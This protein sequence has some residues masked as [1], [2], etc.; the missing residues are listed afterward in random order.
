MFDDRR[1]CESGI[2]GEEFFQRANIVSI[3][4]L[5]ISI[6]ASRLRIYNF[7]AADRTRTIECLMKRIGTYARRSRESGTGPWLLESSSSDDCSLL[8]RSTERYATGSSRLLPARPANL[9]RTLAE[10]SAFPFDRKRKGQ[11]HSDSLASVHR[12][13]VPSRA[14]MPRRLAVC[15]ENNATWA[16]ESAA[17]SCAEIDFVGTKRIDRSRSLNGEIFE[18]CDSFSGWTARFRLIGK[19]DCSRWLLPG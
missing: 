17:P 7:L 9:W 8:W 1:T 5:P 16:T 13:N 11:F 2:R 4:W 19:F 10:T 18:R 3:F 12:A 14:V 15:E 6:G